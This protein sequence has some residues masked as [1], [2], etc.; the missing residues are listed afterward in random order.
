MT[1]MGVREKR[2]SYRAGRLFNDNVINNIAGVGTR[3]V[4]WQTF[5]LG[6]SEV[7][8]NRGYPGMTMNEFYLAK[9]VAAGDISPDDIRVREVIC[10]RQSL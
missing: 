10:H 4:A 1:I 5:Y 7:D 3:R 9:Q 6:E 2:A 8:A